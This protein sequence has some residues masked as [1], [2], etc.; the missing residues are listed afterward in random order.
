VYVEGVNPLVTRDYAHVVDS[1]DDA[2]VAVVRLAAPYQQRNGSFPE[3]RFR[4]GDLDFKQPE[5]TR[6]LDLLGRV[7]TI[8]DIYLERPA[9]IP[10]LAEHSVAL[11]ADFGPTTQ[12]CW[13]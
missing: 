5:R 9:V 7:L 1:P 3:S 12:P 2:D 10:E 13:T 6:I 11:L 4:A 8:V